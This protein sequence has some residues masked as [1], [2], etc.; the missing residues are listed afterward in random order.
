MSQLEQALEAARAANERMRDQLYGNKS[1]RVVAKPTPELPFDEEE[2]QA[3]PPPFRGG[4]PD[5]ETEHAEAKE[6]KKR[7]KRGIRRI[8]ANIPRIETRLEPSQ[9]QRCCS[10]CQSELILIGEERTELLDHKPA[11]FQIQVLV[12]PKYACRHHEENGVVTAELPKRPIPRGMVTAN[13]VAQIAVAKYREHLPL[14]R[15]ARIYLGQGVDIAESTM[16]EWLKAGAELLAP[17]VLEQHKELLQEPI[18][19]SDDTS[20]TVLG[21]NEKKTNTRRGFLWVYLDLE[22]NTL[23]HFTEGRSRAGPLTILKTY[24]GTLLSDAYSAYDAVVR[25]GKIVPA[26]CWAHARRR[27]HKA[28]NDAPDLAAIA[29]EVVR[30]IFAVERKA[31]EA[32]ASSEE[33]LE[34]RREQSRPL[35]GGFRKWLEEIRGSVLPKSAL[36]EAISYTLNQWI[37]LTRFLEDGRLPLENNAA[38]RA[39][40]QVAIGRKNWMFAGSASGGERAALYYSLVVS[41]KNLG[42][43]PYDYLRDVLQRMAEDPSRAAQLTPRAWRAARTAEIATS[44]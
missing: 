12:R 16:G 38:E 33:R 40:R 19:H 9:D 4:S 44:S 42:I 31:S 7:T 27:F 2:A 36:G 30:R 23:F 24:V 13:L 17:I 3:P 29:I 41:C 18:L 35:L 26:G 25:L 10:S 6:S 22:G 1:E 43:E 11:S 21:P 28:R 15:Q 34:L 14:H 32:N 8:P 37:P 39:M 20:I 5:D